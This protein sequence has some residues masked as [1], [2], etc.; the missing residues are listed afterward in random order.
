MFKLLRFWGTQFLRNSVF[1]LLSFWATQF[2][3]YSVFEL[4]SFRATQFFS[5][6]AFKLLS[7]WVTQ[8]FSHS[9]FELLI[10]SSFSTKSVL[11]W[12]AE[13]SS[14]LELQTSLKCTVL[15][16][17]VL[18]D[19]YC[20]AMTVQSTTKKTFLFFFFSSGNVHPCVSIFATLRRHNPFYEPC[21]NGNLVI[22]MS[23]V[24]QR[25]KK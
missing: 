7:F 8:F 5:Y 4:L 16:C 11:L 18:L 12:N 20:S 25:L 14:A 13:T 24:Q 19:N 10:L 3:S 2:L 1:E 17:I 9:V 21:S 23:N 15:S 22:I 6:S